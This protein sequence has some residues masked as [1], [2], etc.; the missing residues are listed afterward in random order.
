MA[1][2]EDAIGTVL[3]NEGGYTWDENDPGGETNFGISKRSYPNVDI[4]NLTVEEASA[5]YQRD[6]WKFDGI[7]DQSV[8]TKLFDSYVN[9]GHTAIRLAQYIVG[10]YEDGMYGPRTE[11]QINGDDPVAF[12]S[13]YRDSLAGHYRDIV[14]ANPSLGRFLAGW[15]RRA[16]Q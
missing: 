12:L 7:N 14:N 9:M 16:A 4:K 6:F 8:A 2:F 11:S 10:V 5:I 3:A 15:L 1:N 13:D